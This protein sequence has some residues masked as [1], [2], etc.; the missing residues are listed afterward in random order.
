MS[1]ANLPADVVI[2]ACESYLQARK[3]RIERESE[4][5]IA[6][7]V[8]VKSWFWGKPMTTEQA[9]DYCSEELGYI[10]IT[11]GYWEQ[12]AE[13]LLSLAQVAKKTNA[14]VA[15]NAKMADFLKTHFQ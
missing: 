13:A 10:R 1:F 11:G 5:E 3:A 8:G 12:E 7:W 6:R 15:V 14:L 4:E 9:R 2:S